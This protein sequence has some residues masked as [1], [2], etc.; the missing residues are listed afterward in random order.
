MVGILKISPTAFSSPLDFL[1]D[2][3][4]ARRRAAKRNGLQQP[5][6]GPRRGWCPTHFFH[7]HATLGLPSLFAPADNRQGASGYDA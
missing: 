7:F 4:G 3:L 5:L 1:S 2:S 6:I